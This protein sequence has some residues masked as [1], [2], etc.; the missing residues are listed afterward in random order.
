MERVEE[1]N[2]STARCKAMELGSTKV[3]SNRN[4]PRQWLCEI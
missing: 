2:N 4:I 3:V 1:I